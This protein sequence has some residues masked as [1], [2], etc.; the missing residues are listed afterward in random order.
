MIKDA[1]LIRLKNYAS[2][3]KVV[4][5]T[6]ILFL[7]QTL[8]LALGI[9]V[10]AIQTRALGP[11]MFGLL[12]FWGA[13]TGFIVLFFRF[14]FFSSLQ[15]LLVMSHSE[16][17][18]RELI[19]AGFIIALMIGFLFAFFLFI[20]SYYI[21][22]IFHVN[23]GNIL[24]MVSPLSFTLPFNFFIPAISTGTNKVENIA[25]FN[26]ISIILFLL[27]LEVLFVCEK[28]SLEVVIS[29][30]LFVSIF[31]TIFIMNR[32]KPLFKSTMLRIN[33]ILRET[34]NYGSKIYLGQVVTQ[35]TY[36]LDQ[37][38]ISYF[39]N[40]IWV[41]YYSL[42]VVLTSPMYIMTNALAVSLF[43]NFSTMNKIPRKVFL[44]NII[45]LSSCAVFFIFL[46]K[47]VVVFLFSEQYIPSTKLITL[48][49]IA[50]LL[51]GLYQPHI[52]F[53]TAHK[54]GYFQRNAAIMVA[55]CNFLA[56]LI[57]VPAYGATGAAI[58]SVISRFFALIAN[59]Y[60]Y[61]RTQHFLTSK[62]TD[63]TI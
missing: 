15:V 45:W 47:Y 60:Y 63:Q 1:I 56:N 31:A 3:K 43:K 52:S 59:H 14:G 10:K 58:A 37:I 44:Y 21:D 41:G 62:F 48:L 33:E 51:Q 7:S 24:R 28:L 34:K 4:H 22:Q 54:Q 50:T 32:F 23:F 2:H 8:V 38:F 35:S 53:L 11:E 55:I 18:E 46:G 12:A 25:K 17:E 39:V 29:V 40:T 61:C 27:L 42:I 13:L 36:K 16:Q 30:N 49:S 6:S 19:G 9:P 57:F 5:Q 20:L 26:L